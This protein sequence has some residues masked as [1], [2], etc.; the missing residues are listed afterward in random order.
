MV[1]GRET[2]KEQGECGKPCW[3]GMCQHRAGHSWVVGKQTTS[4]SLVHS[5]I[6]ILIGPTMCQALQN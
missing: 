5:L 1:W 6:Q 3:E 4:V 2:A